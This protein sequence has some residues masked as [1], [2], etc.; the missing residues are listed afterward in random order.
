MNPLPLASNL[1]PS[2]HP[3]PF[4]FMQVTAGFPSPAL[5]YREK[6]LDLNEHL[7]PN[8]VSTFFMRATNDALKESGILAGDLLIVD[9]SLKPHSGCIVIAGIAGELCIRRF[10]RMDK[11]II[12][13]T[14]EYYN[15][16]FFLRAED[17]LQIWGVVTAAIHSL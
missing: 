8:P 3:L 14:D 11:K 9:R 12:L 6:S 5:D 7:I 16:P 1:F 4:Y 2:Y 13:K 15:E 17:E 10:E